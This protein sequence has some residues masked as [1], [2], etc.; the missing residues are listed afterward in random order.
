MKER[1]KSVE[2][3]I[4][5]AQE[6]GDFED[7]PGKGKPLDLSENPFLDPAMQLTYK[8][9]KDAGFSPAWIEL[10][11]EIRSDLQKAQKLLDTCKLKRQRLSSDQKGLSTFKGYRKRAIE[12]YGEFLKALNLKIERFNMLVPMKDKQRRKIDLL[13]AMKQFDSECPEI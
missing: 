12:E 6:R 1:P 10:D 4:K 13:E 9:M 7:L 8:L 5:E 11:K 3:K 2:E